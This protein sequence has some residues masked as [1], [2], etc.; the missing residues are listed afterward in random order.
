MSP[1]QEH[2]LAAITRRLAPLCRSPQGVLFERRSAYNHIVV[3]RKHNQL[4]LCYRHQQSRVEEVQ[5]RLDP[6][7]PLDLLSPY[8]QAMLLALVWCAQP[9]RILLIGLG[10]GRLQMVL[11]HVFESVQLDTV[12]LDPLVVDIA[13]RFFGFFS[14]ERQ[15]TVIA[16][17]RSYVRTRAAGTTYDLIILD[18]YRAEGVTPH[19]LTHDF[20]VECRACLSP[21]GLVVSN[22]HSSTPVYDAARRTFA[23]V[24]R[25]TTAC[26]VLS[27]NVVVMGSDT[28]SL[29]PRIIRNQTALAER[30]GTSGLPLTTWAQNVS[31]RA[32]YRRRASIL[33]DSGLPA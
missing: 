28:V 17:G 4:L 11:H 26:S 20:Y 30:S 31:F 22:L 5:S 10:G 8:T 29:D 27:G 12:E 9:R 7:S 24:F 19:L 15:R 6:L 32:P 2:N 13:T 3:R 21:H 23:A 18:A 16:D 1:W 25:Y 14:D 33:Q